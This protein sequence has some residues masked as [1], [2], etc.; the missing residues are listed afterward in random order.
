MFSMVSGDLVT[1]SGSAAA[2]FDIIADVLAFTWNR[3][4]NS[5]RDNFRKP[6]DNLKNLSMFDFAT[7]GTNSFFQFVC[8][9]DTLVSGRPGKQTQMKKKQTLNHF[10]GIAQNPSTSYAN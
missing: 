2:A 8:L 5:N 1:T 6:F 7:S 10:H 4:E 9:V 3:L